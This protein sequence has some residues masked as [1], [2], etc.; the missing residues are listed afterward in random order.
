[1][2]APIVRQITSAATAV[3]LLS[4]CATAP[5]RDFAVANAHPQ[6]ATVAS[7]ALLNRPGQVPDDLGSI[8]MP[9][10]Q[11]AGVPAI[12]AAVLS[13]GRIVAHGAVGERRR[14]SS[15]PATLDDQ[16]EIA[17]CA[18]ALS[19]VVIARLVEDGTLAWDRP[20]PTYFPGE[21]LHPD[22]QRVTLRRLLT[23]SAGLHDPIGAFL[24]NTYFEHGTLADKRRAF[25]LR[26]MRQPMAAPSSGD[27]VYNNTDYILAAAVAE[28]VAHRSWERLMSDGVFVPL[29]L[30]S[31]G[32]GP[33]GKPGQTNQP[34]GHGR[35]RV[36]QLGLVGSWPFDPGSV[37][38]DYPAMASPAGYVHLSLADWETFAE[39]HLRGD[40]ANPHRSCVLLRPETFD[41]LHGRLGGS[42][43]GGGWFIGTRRWA[44]GSR[45]GDT[46][47]V[48]YHFGNNGRW[49]SAAW[50]APE[51]DFAV[52]IVCNAGD[53]LGV[54][55]K[56]AAQ[57]V[58]RYATQ[59]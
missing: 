38:A 33:P 12:A 18:K 37:Q 28:T 31:A 43:Y 3:L 21:K 58:N 6:I 30:A 26:L 34:W 8:L 49:T 47:R 2:A 42:D 14:G 53:K 52:L 29:G 15:A 19:A 48:L 55:D 9:V 16:W 25:A 5:Y 27:S 4:S 20:L 50:L 10:T 7:G 41:Q 46:G 51:I 57:L 56:L 39:M 45:P 24:A 54:V 22:W 1:M 32:F 36:L 44:R 13:D 40:A 35:F 11:H 59:R 23:H 17:S